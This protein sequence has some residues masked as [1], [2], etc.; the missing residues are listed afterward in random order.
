MG[1]KFV[2]WSARSSFLYSGGV[3]QS[4]KQVRRKEG[5]EA[6][7]RLLR[8]ARL[9]NKG[10]LSFEPHSFFPAERFSSAIL[11]NSVFPPDFN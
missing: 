10:M 3:G 4:G 9:E 5:S 7:V 11:K 2:F 6:M 1:V 8:V